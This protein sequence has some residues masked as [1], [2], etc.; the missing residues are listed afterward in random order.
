L[1]K[2]LHVST[3]TGKTPNNIETWDCLGLPNQQF[4]L[5]A[6]GKGPIRWAAHPEKCMGVAEGQVENG[7]HIVLRDC[8]Q[9]A[10]DQ[11]F[12]IFGGNSLHI[13]WQ[14]HPSKCFEINGA[15]I[16]NGYSI[17]L[18]DCQKGKSSQEFTVSFL[19]QAIIAK[20]GA[21][22]IPTYDWR[23]GDLRASKMVV[24]SLIFLMV[25]LVVFARVA[26]LPGRSATRSTVLS[27]AE[28]MPYTPVSQ[29]LAEGIRPSL[30]S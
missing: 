27:T 28:E 12:I 15:S 20:H 6:N 1:T 21:A 25:S 18:W 5:P 7:D 16:L 3:G 13:R 8:R 2:C 23:T 30:N 9:G 22:P 4:D 17:V 10:A 19:N 26:A 29:G 11:Q 14:K 24:V